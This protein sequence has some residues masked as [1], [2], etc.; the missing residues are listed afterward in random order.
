ML[1]TGLFTLRIKVVSS[2]IEQIII[3]AC[4]STCA[5]IYSFL[6]QLYSYKPFFQHFLFHFMVTGKLLWSVPV[7]LCENLIRLVFRRGCTSIQRWT[8]REHVTAVEIR[9]W[10]ETSLFFMMST[11]MLQEDTS[12]YSKS[13]YTDCLTNYFESSISIVIKLSFERQKTYTLYW[14]KCK[15]Y[16]TLSL[17]QAFLFNQMFVFLF[18]ELRWVL[19]SSLCSI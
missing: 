11:G 13:L 19:C 2:K 9:V 15:F 12:R 1:D 4:C 3:L 8:N 10:M 14:L 7:M 5:S 16:P 17:L 6:W 18:K